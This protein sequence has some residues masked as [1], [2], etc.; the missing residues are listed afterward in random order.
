MFHVSTTCVTGFVSF[1]F[2]VCLLTLNRSL[3][4]FWFCLLTRHWFVQYQLHLHIGVI[5]QYN[6]G[7]L[8]ADFEQITVSI[9]LFFAWVLCIY[10]ILHES[11]HIL[12]VFGLNSTMCSHIIG[13]HLSSDQVTYGFMVDTDLCN[14][15]LLHLC[16]KSF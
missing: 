1:A 2:M 3:F 7:S 10:I 9:C 5:L 11:C 14:S 12:Y 16:I 15:F 4:W 13:V 8:A 6:S